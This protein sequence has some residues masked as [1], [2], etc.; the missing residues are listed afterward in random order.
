[1]MSELNAL[2]MNIEKH[3]PQFEKE[4]N[5]KLLKRLRLNQPF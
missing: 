2:L 5:K 3:G 1:M 4:G